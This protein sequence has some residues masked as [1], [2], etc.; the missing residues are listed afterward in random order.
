LSGAATLL[1]PARSAFDVAPASAASGAAPLRVL[2]VINGEHYS[3][4]ER[5]Q[6]LLAS[7]LAQFGF[8][9]G[10][11]CLKPGR[12]AG[13]RRAQGSP[14]F[15]ASMQTRFDLRPATRL[16]RLAREQPYALIHSHTPRAA[17]VGWL[18][19][20]L[21]GVPLVHHIHSPTAADSTR[22]WQ[23]RLNA[24]IER[25]SL[26][27]VSAV[28][29]VSQS[30]AA[31][32]AAQGIDETR[33]RV[34]PNGVPAVGPLARRTPPGAKWTLGTV[35]LFRPRKGLEVLLDALAL[36]GGQGLDV[37][38]RAVGEF[39][40]AAYR[41]KIE[42]QVARLAIGDRVD[43]IGFSDDVPGELARF[44]LFV[45]PSLFGE[46]L[47]MVILEAMA[48]GVPVVGTRVEGVREAI[49]DGV[50]GRIVE[51]GDPAGLASVIGQFVRGQADWPSLRA[52]AHR[53][54]ARLFSDYTMA[55][56]VA[57]VYRQ[58]LSP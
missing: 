51:P 15:D 28:I 55:Q 22:K 35:A 3:G 49:R 32:A 40:S 21:A 1:S 24:R 17:L 48:A 12:F 26:C 23:D 44:D 53:R 14:V 38:L 36:L 18:A 34:V 56:G 13:L 39:E 20:L 46:G 52:A 33:I 37:R 11:A 2:H 54:Q 8:E 4:A 27:G 57:E 29:A 30:M 9:V 47:P 7:N 16:A 25:L 19:A 6:D 43:W 50:D 42:R 58:V 31:Y 41:M 10:F 5:V 45:L